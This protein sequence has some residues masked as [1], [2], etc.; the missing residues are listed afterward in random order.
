MNASSTD[1]LMHALEARF[2]MQFYNEQEIGPDNGPTGGDYGYYGSSWG[3]YGS[4]NGYVGTYQV[5]NDN[6]GAMLDDGT[7]TDGSAGAFP[8]YPDPHICLADPQFPGCPA[9]QQSSRCTICR[10]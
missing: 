5:A 2:E 1:F 6:S 9:E 3:N 7:F 10:C 8:S 4:G